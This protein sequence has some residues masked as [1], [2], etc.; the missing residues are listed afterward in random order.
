[1]QQSVFR[2]LVNLLLLV[3]IANAVWR[4]APVFYAYFV[5][6]EQVAETARWSGGRPD[7]ETRQILLEMAR[8][9]NI[10]M[11]DEN[12]VVTR[13]G[14]RL[15]IDARY[16]QKLEIVPLYFYDYEFTISVDTLL[17][18]PRAVDEIR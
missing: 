16:V 17:A 13:Q 10:P 11:L 2:R 4:T 7:R 15:L 6:R 18:R 8:R 1:M 3:L 14:Q 5:Y 9:S 12:L